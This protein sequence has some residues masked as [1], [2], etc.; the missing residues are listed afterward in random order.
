MGILKS[1]LRKFNSPDYK[2]KYL[3]HLPL[4]FLR[5]VPHHRD[6]DCEA[7]QRPQPRRSPRHS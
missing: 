5:Q 4:G 2:K 7:D 3:R 6:R 1:T